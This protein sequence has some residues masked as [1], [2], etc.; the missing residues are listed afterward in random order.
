MFDLLESLPGCGLPGPRGDD[1]GLQ[2]RCVPPQDQ[3]DHVGRH[4]GSEGGD[5][6][7]EP[8][9][10]AREPEVLRGEKRGTRRE[11]TEGLL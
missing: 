10:D 3:V 1:G 9:R 2:R 5:R 7:P 11:E 8:P 6:P 4:I